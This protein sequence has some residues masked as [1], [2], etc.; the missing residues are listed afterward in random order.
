MCSSIKT[1][2]YSL[3]DKTETM[4]FIFLLRAFCP[5]FMFFIY[6]VFNPLCIVVKLYGYRKEKKTR[7]YLLFTAFNR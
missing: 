5:I 7:G 6:L 4:L 3:L 2:I 1:A